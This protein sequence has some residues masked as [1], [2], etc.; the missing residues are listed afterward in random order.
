[1]VNSIYGLSLREVLIGCSLF[2]SV[3]VSGQ[4]DMSRGDYLQQLIKVLPEDRTQ[5]P[6]D[7]LPGTPPPHVSPEDRN[8]GEWLKR[9]G[10]LPPDFDEMPA[11][12]FLPD[13]L[14][15]DQGG[16]NIPVV[17]MEQ[18]TRKRAEM[19]RL[20]QHWITGTIPP[21]PENLKAEVI[22]EKKTG[23][24]TE[25]TILLTFGPGNKAQLHVNLLI[26]PGEGPFPVFI[27]PWKK[28]RYD[29]VQA[30]VRRGYV[31][32]RF[33]A[34]DP[35]Y[36]YPDDSEAYEELWWPDYDFS[37]LMRWGWAA[38][39]A[40]DYLYTLDNVNKQQIALTGLSRNG[41]MALWTAAYD[42]R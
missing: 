20:A 36:G 29:W 3:M 24:L 39:R 25:R 26:P 28:D 37:A 41:K 18:W 35:K 12:P 27:C 2:L 9:T 5:G 23:P 15:L 40:I 7:Q 11:L 4:K 10:E 6:G 32:C 1:M 42:E 19:K 30:A 34:T 14:V 38:S 21:T 16:E 31:A 17:T 8:W 33:T 22:D 13:P